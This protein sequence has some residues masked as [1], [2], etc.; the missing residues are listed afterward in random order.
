MASTTAFSWHWKFFESLDVSTLYSL[1]ALRSEVFVVEQTC[2][3]QDL[4][5]LDKQA[6]HFYALNEQ[7][8]PVAYCRVIPA[9]LH[10]SEIAIGRVVTD[11]SVR[12]IGLGHE[13]MQRTLEAIEKQW[14]PAPIRIS[15]QEHLQGYY[16]HWGFEKLGEMYL[17]DGIPHVE[18]LL[19]KSS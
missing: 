16:H 18:M 2:V 14:G 13:M 7:A 9:G 4:D 6:F 11:P 15:A 10:Y 12:G 17:E 3:Y 19:T 8:L 5:G 1:L